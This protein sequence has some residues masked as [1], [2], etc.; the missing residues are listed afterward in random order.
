MSLPGTVGFPTLLSVLQGFQLSVSTILAFCT[1]LPLAA[2][3]LSR[4]DENVS[5]EIRY[6]GGHPALLCSEAIS[7]ISRLPLVYQSRVQTDNILA[8]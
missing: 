5:A 2:P 7:G 6:P 3:K 1:G 4:L 8:M